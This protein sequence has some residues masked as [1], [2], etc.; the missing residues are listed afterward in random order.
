MFYQ[1]LL[2]GEFVVFGGAG[3]LFG[4][5]GIDSVHPGSLQHRIRLD[6]EGPQGCAGVGGEEGIAGAAGDQGHSAFLHKLDGVVA[7]VELGEGGH[8][9]GGENLSGYALGTEGGRE[10]Q[11]VDDGGQHP[12][13]VPGHAV[14]SFSYA[15]DTAE[16]IP[17][18][19]HYGDLVSGLHRRGYLAGELGEARFI[20]AFAR[21]AA[22][23]FAADFQKN[24]LIH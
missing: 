16:D 4:I 3:I 13:A 10:C 11:R 9:G 21:R 17:A 1:G 2:E 23:A 12:H 18:A 19:V 6:F 24:S 22:Q 14:V 20:Q 8:I 15:L 5:G 7:V